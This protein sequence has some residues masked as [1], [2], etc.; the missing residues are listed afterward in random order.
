MLLKYKYYN[1]SELF[2]CICSAASVHSYIVWI[3]QS[4]KPNIS[5]FLNAINKTVIIYITGA[6]LDWNP[7]ACATPKNTKK[8]F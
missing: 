3:E 1:L 2:T 5:T 8:K 6:D 4:L 7:G